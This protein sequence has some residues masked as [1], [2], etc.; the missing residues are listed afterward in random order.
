MGAAPHQTR[1]IIMP[2]MPKTGGNGR[3]GHL[4]AG[5]AQQAEDQDGVPGSD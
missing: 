3:A 5:E 1:P 4:Q 2:T